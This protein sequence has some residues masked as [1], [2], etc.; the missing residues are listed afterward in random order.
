MSDQSKIKR[1]TVKLEE[2]DKTIKMLEELGN[3]VQIELIDVYHPNNM[4]VDISYRN[5]NDKKPLP[6]IVR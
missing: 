6:P 3:V 1:L 2:A 4:T 5:M